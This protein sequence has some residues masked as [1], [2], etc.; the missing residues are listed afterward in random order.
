MCCNSAEKFS[1]FKLG[2]N[3]PSANKFDFLKL[4]K[5]TR[6][7][8]IKGEVFVS[9]F[10]SLVDIPNS[11]LF[12]VSETNQSGVQGSKFQNHW[13]AT[14]EG[15]QKK[16]EGSG[17]NTVIGQVVQ[18]RKDTKLC[19][20]TQVL[21]FRFHKNGIIVHLKGVEDVNT[22]ESL[23]EG[24]FFVPHQIFSSLEGENMYLCEILNFEV[25]D[26]KRGVLGKITAFS[27]NGMQ[28]LL[29]VQRS[30]G[31][32]EAQ[33]EKGEGRMVLNGSTSFKGVR[34]GEGHKCEP[35]TLTLKKIKVREEGKQ[36]TTQPVEIP[37]IK[38][39]ILD[40]DFELKQVRVDLY[41]G[42]PGLD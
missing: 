12:S 2:E 24:H 33:R 18:I 1:Q 25:Y 26:K 22:A 40:I 7:H 5:V 13:P 36:K 19:L 16:R 8:G 30:R 34:R 32:K 29:I 3:S 17:F 39:F 41:E 6:T 27:D 9:L 4:G 20:E 28:D 38:E 15:K 42:W 14:K 35:D 10:A 23:K 21:A 37:F 11:A 31:F